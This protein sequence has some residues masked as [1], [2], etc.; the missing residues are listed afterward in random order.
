MH[1]VAARMREGR[2]KGG[3][4]ALHAVKNARERGVESRIFAYVSFI[5][6]HTLCDLLFGQVLRA[7]QRCTAGAAAVAPPVG[8]LAVPFVLSL[9]LGGLPER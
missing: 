8:M 1:F 7:N 6:I 9:V 4:G 2:W 3:G 5:G